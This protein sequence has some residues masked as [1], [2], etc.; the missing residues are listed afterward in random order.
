MGKIVFGIKKDMS[1]MELYNE[2]HGRISG[3]TQGQA[4]T[5]LQS[6][7]EGKTDI[8]IDPTSEYS[9]VRVTATTQDLMNNPILSYRYFLMGIND[10]GLYFTHEL[11]ANDVW[12]HKTFEELLMWVNRADQGFSHRVQG[13]ILVQF[14]KL[15]IRKDCSERERIEV[16]LSNNE[17][18]DYWEKLDPNKYNDAG[19]VGNRMG[20]HKIISNDIYY[21]SRDYRLVQGKE[22]ILEHPH[23]GITKMGIPEGFSALLAS[24]RGRA[25]QNID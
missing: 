16:R 17:I 14:V 22:L 15:T 5:T 12:R 24:Q 2:L 8:F 25:G 20:N 13:D 7:Q 18:A 9:L 6:I 19:Y 10:E 4:A 21:N 23:H 11:N 3:E 1:N